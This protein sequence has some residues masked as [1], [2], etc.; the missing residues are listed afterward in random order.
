MKKNKKT[1]RNF[2]AGA[3]AFDKLVEKIGFD[4]AVAAMCA[5]ATVSQF[6]HVVCADA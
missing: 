1:N 4:N 2:I 3:L 5:T 6:I